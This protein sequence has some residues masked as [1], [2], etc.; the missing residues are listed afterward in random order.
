M[1]IDSTID[2]YDSDRIGVDR[3]V[4]ALAAKQGT[5]QDPREFAREIFERFADVGLLV[6]VA[7]AT[8]N[9]GEHDEHYG[10]AVMVSGRVDPEAEF[11]HERMS[12]EVRADILGQ[13]GERVGSAPVAMPGAGGLW[14]PR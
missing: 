3:V 4:N 5:M 12:H 13:R 9:P 6:D 11:D 1:E 10:F 14:T 2:L 7:V 8:I